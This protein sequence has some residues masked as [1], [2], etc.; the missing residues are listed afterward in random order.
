MQDF[1]NSEFNFTLEIIIEVKLNSF[2]YNFGN[3]FPQRPLCLFKCFCKFE[4]FTGALVN[5]VFN[6][7]RF[8]LFHLIKP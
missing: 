4:S 5:M 1:I 3:T 7:I 2:S 6:Q 8:Y